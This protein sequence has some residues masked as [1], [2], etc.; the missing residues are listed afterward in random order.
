MDLKEVLEKIASLQL[1]IEGIVKMQKDAEEK[2]SAEKNAA[3]KKKV[4]VELD[5]YKEDLNGLE[6]M[7]TD[8]E[9]MKTSLETSKKENEKLHLEAKT[10]RVE[11][12]LKDLKISGK[13]LPAFEAEAK[14]LL[15]ELNEESKLGKFSKVNKDGKTSEAELSWFEAFQNL[16][17]KLPKL[18]DFKEGTPAGKEGDEDMENEMKHRDDTFQLDDVELETEVKKYMKENKDVSYMDATIAVSAKFKKEGKE[19]GLSEE[20]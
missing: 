1:T 19:Q 10:G 20:E 6:T 18:I 9:K 4:Q 17:S 13:L 11:N 12:F 3:E 16:L 8:Y 2:F 7:K 14:A 15:M 5:K